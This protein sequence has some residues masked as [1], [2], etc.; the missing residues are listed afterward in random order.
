MRPDVII[1]GSGMG[2]ATLAASLAL[3]GR[4]ILI[5]ERGEYLRP[6]AQDR[7]AD[8]IF[9][10]GIFRPNEEWFNGKDEPFD[11]GNYYNVGGNSKF[12]GAVL[13]RYRAQD[14]NVVRH[15]GGSTS[16]MADKV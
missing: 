10:D 1:I 13:I 4:R 3:S 16:G 11:P 14:F 15:H 7:D 9:G 6:S 8:A 5:L 2:G 12:Y